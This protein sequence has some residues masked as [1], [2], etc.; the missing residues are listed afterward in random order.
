MVKNGIVIYPEQLTGEFIIKRDLN[1]TPAPVKM[2]LY[3][4]EYNVHL[5]NI[6]SPEDKV[7]TKIIAHANDNGDKAPGKCATYAVKTVVLKMFF[8]ETGENDESRA[9]ETNF[10]T[11]SDDQQQQLIALMV[12]PDGNWTPKGSKVARA[13][14]IQDFANIKSNK[15]NQILKAAQ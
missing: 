14:K 3:E 6:D 12:D 8:L 7:T 1:A 4:G 11:I 2:G 13:F 10:D 5:I 9:E 15:F